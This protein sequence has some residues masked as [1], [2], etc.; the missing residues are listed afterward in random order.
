MMADL[1]LQS[2]RFSVAWPRV[3]PD[4]RG[5][6]N[7]EGLAFYHRLVELLLDNGIKPCPTL[8]H[9][10]LPQALEDIGGFRSRDTVSWFADYAALM[11]RE[12]GD[13]VSMWS[14]FNEPWCYAYLGHASGYH[15]PGLTDPKAAVTVAHHRAARPRPR[16]PVDA[17]RAQ[18]PRARAS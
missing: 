10:D 15:A 7:G 14:T 3:I 8:F 17:R 12:L 4:G 16:P 6:V 9:W 2:Y 5:H 13:K 1:G 11:A 18:R